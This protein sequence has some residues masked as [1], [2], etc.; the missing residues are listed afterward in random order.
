MCVGS[1]IQAI[2]DAIE[3]ILQK[4]N[5]NHKDIKEVIIDIPS[6]RFHIVNDR[7]I[8]NICAQ[9]LAALYLV[10]KKIGY[11][12]VHDEKLFS[13]IDV[14]KL[15]KKIIARP[16][17]ELAIA[18]PERQAKVKIIFNDSTELSHHAR[19]VRGTPDNPMSEE[20]IANK[21]KEL[22]K[23]FEVKKVHQLIDIVLN[24]EFL[25]EELMVALDFK[26]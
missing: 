11:E 24:K 8:P 18:R 26:I 16:S 19:A 2:L 25:I 22:L 9:H 17:D 20:E 21:A 5:F 13:D 4:K 7:S 14:I 6:D 10:K 1:H 23:S 12:E 15:R 3:A